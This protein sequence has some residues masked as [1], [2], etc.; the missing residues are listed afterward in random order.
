MQVEAAIFLRF[1]MTYKKRICGLCV[2]YKI[3]NPT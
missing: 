3:K 1:G 2:L